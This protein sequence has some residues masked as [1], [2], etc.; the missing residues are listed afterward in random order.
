MAAGCAVAEAAGGL[1]ARGAVEGGRFAGGGGVGRCRGGESGLGPLLLLGFVAVL[2]ARRFATEGGGGRRAGDVR[3][4]PSAPAA[5]SVGVARPEACCDRIG[6]AVRGGGTC[7]GARTAARGSVG[8]GAAKADAAGRTGVWGRADGGGGGRDAALVESPVGLRARCWADCGTDGGPLR[9]GDEVLLAA[10]G[11]VLG[12][13]LGG[14]GARAG[15]LVPDGDG[16]LLGGGGG[17]T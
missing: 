9:G 11:A 6:D 3:C 13:R 16:R 15:L 12:G 1:P 2:A 17:I 7:S 8:V 5:A 4:A 10:V 14:G